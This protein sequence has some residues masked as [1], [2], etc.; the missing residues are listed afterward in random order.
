MADK[1]FDIQVKIKATSEDAALS[2]VQKQMGDVAAKIKQTSTE[3][4][5]A[6]GSFGRFGGAIGR[7][8]GAL[9]GLAILHT[10]TGWIK[11]GVASAAQ[12]ERAL[13]AL[14]VM[15]RQFDPAVQGLSDSLE[16]FVGK[17]QRV[18]AEDGA[19]LEGIRQLI[20][21]TKNYEEATK[22]VALAWDLSVATGRSY[23]EMLDLI[24]GLVANNP[25][26]LKQA[27]RE[28]GI[29]AA[30]CQEALD[31]L[32]GQFN[33]Y[34]AKIDD[35]LNDLTRLKNG[36]AN[37]KEFLGTS[38]M[39]AYDYYMKLF[40]TKTQRMA[41]KV[42]E[43]LQSITPTGSGPWIALQN[44]ISAA[45]SKLADFEAQ[46]K[47]A[48]KAVNQAGAPRARSVFAPEGGAGGGRATRG[49]GGEESEPVGGSLV[50]T[51][52]IDSELNAQLK[53]ERK[54]LTNS[55]AQ[56]KNYNKQKEK[57]DEQ[58]TANFE[59]M[60]RRKKEAQYALASMTSQ[61]IMTMFGKNKAAASAAAL[62]DAFAAAAKSNAAYPQ[63][64]GAIM[65]ALAL[66]L[67]MA[68][69]VAI[70][71]TK[72]PSAS[73]AQGFDIPPGL[74]PVTQLHEKEMVLP[75]EQADVIR[76]LASSTT[77]NYGGNKT[78]VV[79]AMTGAYG[80]REASKRMK[81]GDRFYKS[82]RVR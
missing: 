35:H 68:Q 44:L 18:G 4:N 77:N 20:P 81:K 74:N 8:A 42:L 73:A 9:G 57:S 66:A 12:E 1:S 31:K 19:V 37:F 79:N 10:V 64:Y 63:P 11:E 50:L 39:T 60:Q 51:P 76:R 28:L 47:E 46:A 6:E 26:S 16:T 2:M 32:Y 17:M 56:W 82:V 24:A 54:Y 48:A 29:E 49:A 41:V 80:L 3:A 15:V 67:G 22:G 25:R 59:E 71:N 61:F 53:S 7:L 78:I 69:V 27:Q 40:T 5:Q 72:A 33:G 23:N 14:T 43:A 52:D 55:L 45:T 21:I 30:T 38:V 75:A 58:E 34:S 62:I 70:N 13:N 65:A 36:W